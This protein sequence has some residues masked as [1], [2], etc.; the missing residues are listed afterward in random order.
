M[1]NH[2][3]A[4]C[5]LETTQ[6]NHAIRELLPEYATLAVL[7]QAPEKIYPPVAAHLNICETC[8]AEFAELLSLTT[9]MYSEQ[10]AVPSSYPSFDLTFLSQPTAA[11]PPP[12][13]PWRIDALGHVIIMFSEQLLKT[14]YQPSLAGALRGQLLC[15]YTP[16]AGALPD[17]HVLVE[18][19]AEDTAGAVGRV[20]VDVDVPSRG[21]FDQSGSQVLLRADGIIWQGETD[22]LGSVDFAP[23]P[24]ESLPRLRV[25]ITPQRHTPD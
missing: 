3:H 9:D 4:H 7:G 11:S 10:V 8:R 13:Q 22:E 5:F 18:T 23:F 14:L 12:H 17:L 6:L 15:R 19:F 25:Q 24:L 21:P 16:E 2:T 1:K 20:R